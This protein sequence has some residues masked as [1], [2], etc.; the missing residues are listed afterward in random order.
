MLLLPET[1]VDEAQNVAERLRRLVE[2][3]ELSIASCAINATVSIGVVQA[4]PYMETL[5]D[6]IKMTDQ[7]L[8]AAKNAGRNRVWAPVQSAH[9]RRLGLT[10]G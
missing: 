4:N 1:D 10:V 3:R 2:A 6:L 9:A 5:F 8:Y 7:A